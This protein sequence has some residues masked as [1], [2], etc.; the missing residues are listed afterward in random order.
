MK[1]IKGMECLKL[2]N[3]FRHYGEIISNE[4]YPAL[5]VRCLWI[6]YK[7][8]VICFFLKYGEVIGAVR[9]EK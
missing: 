2:Y 9:K 7:D 3:D 6:N 8:E 5:C 1:F 4:D